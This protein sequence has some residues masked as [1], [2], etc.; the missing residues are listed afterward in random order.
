MRGEKRL[1]ALACIPLATTLWVSYRAVVEWQRSAMEVAESRAETAADL[2]MTAL[3]RDMAAVQASVLSR[4]DDDEADGTDLS[5]ADLI[6]SALAR[7]P[8]PEVF[9]ASRTAPRKQGVIFYSRPDRSPQWIHADETSDPFP[10]VVGTETRV[11]QR[12]LHRVALDA[13]VGRR[14]AVFD[15][16]IDGRMY[17]IVAH[18]SYRDPFH[19][20][21]TE[22]FG[23]MVDLSWAQEHY[24]SELTAQ[25]A[26]VLLESSGGIRLMILNAQDTPVAGRKLD[27][28]GIAARRQFSRLFFDPRLV[29]VEWPGDLARQ[30]WTIQAVAEQDPT[31]TAATLGAQRTL[32]IAIVS[33]LALAISFVLIVQAL[34]ANARL[35][36]MRSE[37]ISSITHELNTP[38]STIRAIGETFA[39]NR[40]ITTDVLRKYGRVAAN[41]AKRLERLVG[42]LLTYARM[43]DVTETYTFESVAPQMLVE[44]TL[45]DF[46]SQLEYGNFDVVVDMPPTLPDVWA[47]RRSMSLALGNLVDNAI[48]YSKGSRYLHISAHRNGSGVVI[49]VTDKGRG[50]P[51]S[52]ILYLTKRFFRGQNSSG[53]GGSGLGL[54]IVARIISDHRGSI[55]FKSVV[56]AG[57]TASL[58]VPIAED[59]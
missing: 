12:L 27:H 13:N 16:E 2:L 29:A 54:A 24:F 43:T 39:S 47:D 56:G 1:L 34:R 20:Q 7:Y 23:F 52:D 5:Q 36:D 32:A 28:N 48:R 55:E 31:L 40:G 26:R 33:A 14:Y 42:N 59:Q 51:P 49:D 3:A 30:V 41:E 46:A 22:I 11:A 37:F 8:Y 4:R 58:T 57:T 6:A 45:R 10:V 15:M 38:I 9:F 17:Q 35:T 50:I 44:D 53:T 21:L 18:L 25:V 19:E